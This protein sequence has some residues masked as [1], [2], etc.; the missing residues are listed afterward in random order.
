MA[1]KLWIIEHVPNDYV[2]VSEPNF[3]ILKLPARCIRDKFTYIGCG[4][5]FPQYIT[6]FDVVN[7]RVHVF[8]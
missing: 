7:C 4:E 6:M 1:I 3:V 8:I 5:G 2:Q